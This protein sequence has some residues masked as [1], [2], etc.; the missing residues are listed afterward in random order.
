M[1]AQRSIK[2]SWASASLDGAHVV[3]S[4]LDRQRAS[5]RRCFRSAD[6][7][8]AHIQC[9]STLF[10]ERAMPLSRTLIRPS[11]GVQHTG[12]SCDSGVFLAMIVS[13]FKDSHHSIFT[14]LLLQAYPRLGVLVKS[15]GQGLTKSAHGRLV[16]VIW[17]SNPHFIRH[18]ALTFVYFQACRS[19][20][21]S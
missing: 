17:R 9:V 20:L 4:T 3:V 1:V 15:L 16:S 7:F 11:A 10:L 5:S 6:A 12:R 19:R 2:L 21:S 13:A 18:F 14:V 8:T